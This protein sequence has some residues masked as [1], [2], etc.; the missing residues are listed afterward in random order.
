M[1]FITPIAATKMWFAWTGALWAQQI[2]VAQVMT[3]AA[4]QGSFAMMGIEPPKP[5]AADPGAETRAKRRAASPRVMGAIKEAGQT[6]RPTRKLA[7]PPS[8]PPRRTH[9]TPV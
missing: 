4:Q 9:A 5:Q 8:M 1:T 6:R 3:E 7:S 2:K